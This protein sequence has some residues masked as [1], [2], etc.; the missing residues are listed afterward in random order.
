MSVYDQTTVFD[1]AFPEA[2]YNFDTPPPQ[3]AVGPIKA[4][5]VSVSNRIEQ[6]LADYAALQVQ[7]SVQNA[8]G[9]YL[10]AHGVLY[11]VPRL[12]GELDVPYRARILA[13]ITRGRLTIPALEAALNAY[14]ASTAVAGGNEISGFVYDLQSDPGAC[15]TDAGRGHPILMFQFVVEISYA[16]K[17]SDV[18][19]LNYSY[20]T[21]DEADPLCLVSS[22]VSYALAPTDPALGA[23]ITVTKAANTQPVYKTIPV[24]EVGV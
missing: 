10:D 17:E 21:V 4:I 13:A 23:T 14:L 16:V 3:Y 5:L 22:S 6:L 9:T 7:L 15:A 12:A 8:T 20:L 19:F 18:F 1:D 11:G 2:P 24:L